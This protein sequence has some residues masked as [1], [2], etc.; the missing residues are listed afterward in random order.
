M[1]RELNEGDTYGE[2]QSLGL[3]QSSNC[4][5]KAGG[6]SCLDLVGDKDVVQKLFQA[7]GG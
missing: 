5:I 3:V 1:I 7:E 4:E 2:T 6:S